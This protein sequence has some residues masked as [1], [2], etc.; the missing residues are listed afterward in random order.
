MLRCL[1]VEEICAACGASKA[2]QS[3]GGIVQSMELIGYEH[4]LSL[5]NWSL[6]SLSQANPTLPSLPSVHLHCAVC[7]RR[8]WYCHTKSLPSANWLHCRQQSITS[9]SALAS[10]NDMNEHC[11]V[12]RKAAQEID[13]HW[14]VELRGRANEFVP[15]S[16]A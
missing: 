2:V 1:A 14:A 4:T 9:T 5:V 10:K 15:A 6:P 13:C 3:I 16:G 8:N 7:A 11:N 12:H